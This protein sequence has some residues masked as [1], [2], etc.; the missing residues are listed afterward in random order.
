VQLLHA[1]LLSAEASTGVVGVAAALLAA[2]VGHVTNGT[3][4]VNPL[5]YALF[6]F[7]LLSSLVGFAALMFSIGFRRGRGGDRAAG[8]RPQVYNDF[9]GA[10][11]DSL[12]FGSDGA[13]IRPL[14]SLRKPLREGQS[15][16]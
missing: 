7:G 9:R 5:W 6:A 11:I 13:V 3:L 16:A 14:R 15:K 8:D 2:S 10:R 12:Y 1:P 4:N